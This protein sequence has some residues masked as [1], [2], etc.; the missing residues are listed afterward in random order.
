MSNVWSLQWTNMETGETRLCEVE[1]GISYEIGTRLLMVHQAAR[2]NSWSLKFKGSSRYRA[3]PLPYAGEL[4]DW[5][6]VA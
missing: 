4:P 5:F 6:G 3:V 2:R 1:G